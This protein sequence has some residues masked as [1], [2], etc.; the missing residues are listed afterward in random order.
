VVELDDKDT[1]SELRSDAA[2]AFKNSENEERATGVAA[3]ASSLNIDADRS[4]AGSRSQYTPS[5]P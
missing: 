2:S 5:L 4:T 1:S 3:S